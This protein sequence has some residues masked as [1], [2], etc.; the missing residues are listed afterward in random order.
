[1]SKAVK[2]KVKAKAKSEPELK[3]FDPLAELD[4]ELDMIEKKFGL[5]SAMLDKNEPRLSTGLLAVDLLLNGGIVSGGWYTTFGGEQSC[6]STLT[7][8]LLASIIKQKFRGAASVFDYEGSSDPQYIDS[9]CRVMGVTETYQR[10]MGVSDDEGNWIVAPLVRYYA[11][12]SGDTFFD[13]MNKLK[14]LLPDKLRIGS[15]HYFLYPHEKKLLKKMAGSYDKK[16]LSKKNRI[17]IPAPDGLP[18]AIAICDSYPAMLPSEQDDDD[19]SGALALQA[20]MFSTG[21]K[22]IKGSMRRK[23]IIVF[24]VNQIRKAPMVK[25]GSPEYEPCGEA[26]KFFCHSGDTYINTTEGLRKARDIHNT[27]NERPVTFQTK[28]GIETSFIY[29]VQNEG[30]HVPTKT[31]HLRNGTS[32]TAD[33]KHLT[34]FMFRAEAKL[35]SD[36]VNFDNEGTEERSSIIPMVD[37]LYLD[38]PTLTKSETFAICIPNNIDDT[39]Q[40]YNQITWDEN[41]NGK[42]EN[43]ILSINDVEAHNMGT[44]T[45]KDFLYPDVAEYSIEKEV[46]FNGEFVPDTIMT[47]KK[48]VKAAF[49][50]GVAETIHL[51]RPTSVD[52]NLPLVQDYENKY[53]ESNMMLWPIPKDSSFSLLLQ[54]LDVEVIIENRRYPI[55]MITID[56]YNRLIELGMQ[57]MGEKLPVPWEQRKVIRDLRQIAN[58]K[59][60]FEYIE[61]QLQE[62]TTWEELNNVLS[63]L[64]DFIGDLYAE[65]E[66]FTDVRHDQ[67]IELLAHLVDITGQLA[68]MPNSSLVSVAKVSDGNSEVLYDTNAPETATVLTNGI[69]SHNSDVRMRTSPRV[70]QFGFTAGNGSGMTMTEPC[71]LGEGEDT[72]RFINI[73]AIKNKLGGI[74]YLD[75]WMRLWISDSSGVAR[76]FDP[77]FDTWIFLKELKYVTGTKKK[78]KFHEDTPLAGAKDVDWHT[79]KTLVIGDKAT[80]KETCEG[81]GIKPISIRLWCKKLMN[82]GKGMA[83]FKAAVITKVVKD[84]DE[85]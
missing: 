23:R 32:L 66:N 52:I 11:P 76:G 62:C 75:G 46:I 27:I 48:S 41:I 5:A 17:K 21:I 80:V 16:Y 34:M 19:P 57:N 36:T 73:K 54:Q 47:S 50:L 28:S 33:P 43:I 24:G 71:I 55:P 13:Y 6:K 78:M 31:L 29:E 68:E 4:D 40:P 8:T 18:Q 15:Q 70:L 3:I 85:D 1:M 72:Y 63:G 22:R 45:A 7:M 82:N 35:D 39:D 51:Y 69:V 67:L 2:T 74:P 65:E 81:L 49:V 14:R 59:D 9:I 53:I 10:I 61:P 26:L 84:A 37:W 12:D 56:G 83:R 38:S 20:R 30:A 79:F 58:N 64:D 25:F 42:D 77:V 44:T 60:Y